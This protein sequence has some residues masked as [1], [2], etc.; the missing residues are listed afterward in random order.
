[1]LDVG[2]GDGV[3]LVAAS[4]LTTGGVVVGLDV[5]ARRITHA[6][7]RTRELAWSGRVRVQVASVLDPGVLDGPFDKAY[8]INSIHWWSDPVLGLRNIRDVLTESGRLAVTLDVGSKPTGKSCAQK[9]RWLESRLTDAGFPVTSARCM[10]S[11]SASVVCVL[12]ALRP[13][14]VSDETGQP[15][16][17]RRG[18]KQGVT[19]T[20]SGAHCCIA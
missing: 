2:C 9:A 10:H 19:S 13:P 11:A 3:G 18:G 14:A 4:R 12:A 7:I 5:S 17:W 1:V 16:V 20:H 8:S 6:R 15:G